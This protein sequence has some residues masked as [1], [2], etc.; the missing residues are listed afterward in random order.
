MPIFK[1]YNK[2]EAAVNWYVILP[3]V[4]TCYENKSSI[5]LSGIYVEDMNK[6]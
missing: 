1:V 5:M 6:K 4:L 3:M 2:Y